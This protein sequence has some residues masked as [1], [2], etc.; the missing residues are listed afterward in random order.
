[1]S[2]ELPQVGRHAHYSQGGRKT[3]SG[4][5]SFREEERNLFDTG[6]Q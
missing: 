5:G 6:V 4:T 3:L 2:A 1:M